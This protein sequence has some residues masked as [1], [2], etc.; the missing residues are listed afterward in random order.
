MVNSHPALAATTTT[1]PTT[2]IPATTIPTTTVST[3]TVSTST[4]PP[5]T[6]TTSPPV[7]TGEGLLRLALAAPGTSW[8]RPA[9]RY[10]G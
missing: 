2:T 3:S 8:G 5:A 4:V 9:Q 10:R 1:I 7:V 6:T